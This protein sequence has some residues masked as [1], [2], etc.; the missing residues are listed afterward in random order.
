MRAS[1]PSGN[2]SFRSAHLLWLS[3]GQLATAYKTRCNDLMTDSHTRM[4]AAADRIA[5]ATEHALAAINAGTA[6]FTHLYNAMSG[7]GAR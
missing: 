6:G 7:Q 1:T 3:N 5:S 4:H 2:L